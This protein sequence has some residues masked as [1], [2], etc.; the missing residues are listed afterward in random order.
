RGVHL[1]AHYG[2]IQTAAAVFAANP[3]L[4]DDPGAL[5]SAA[6]NEGFLRLMLRYQPDLPKRRAVAGTRGLTEL[7]FAHGMNPSHPDWLGITPLHEFARKG[8]LENAAIFL[9]HGAD[10][11]A[12]DENICSTPLG[13]AAKFGKTLMVEFLLRRGAKLMLPDDPPWATPLAW[14]T[15]RGH[16]RVVALLKQYEKDRTPAGALSLEQ[17]ESL[18]RDFVEAYSSGDSAAIGRIKDHF[19]LDRT[20]NRDGLREFVRRRLG[21]PSDAESK[22]YELSLSDAQLL[23]AHAHGFETWSQLQKHFNE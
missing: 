17:C 4:A 18:A 23:V 15:R 21:L 20:P 3:A 2:D 11:H 22:S 16:D 6:G 1:L 19:E 8:D 14:A 7:L 13:W 5:G 10:I 12:R 9:D